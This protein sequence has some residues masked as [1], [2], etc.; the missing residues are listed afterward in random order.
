MSVCVIGTRV[1]VWKFNLPK[2]AW[3]DGTFKLCHDCG[4]RV[5]DFRS[6]FWM[7]ARER[8][9]PV[10][11]RRITRSF[12]GC[13]KRNCLVCFHRPERGW[14]H[15]GLHGVVETMSGKERRCHRSLH[16]P[17]EHA[18]TIRRTLASGNTNFPKYVLF[19]H[20]LV[21]KVN[22]FD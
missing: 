4:T 18:A 7:N 14:K 16:S 21:F 19:I 3:L 13:L 17:Q 12:Q 10:T 6:I 1:T 20:K 2:P 22:Y 11:K 15:D 9:Q 8:F 5:V